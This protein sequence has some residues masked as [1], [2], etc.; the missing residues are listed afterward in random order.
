MKEKER[1]EV[2]SEIRARSKGTLGRE[3]IMYLG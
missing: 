3:V 1:K 2:Y